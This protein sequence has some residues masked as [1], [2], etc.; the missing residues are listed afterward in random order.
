MMEENATIIALCNNDNKRVYSSK[1]LCAV[2]GNYQQERESPEE[3]ESDPDGR[4]G[5][6]R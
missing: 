5:E 4:G 3:S 6:K 2:F 1:K